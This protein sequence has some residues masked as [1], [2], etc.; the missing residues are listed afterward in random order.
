V[1]VTPTSAAIAPADIAVSNAANKN[2]FIIAS[3]LLIECV[4]SG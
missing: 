2:R 3:G 4:K 1:I